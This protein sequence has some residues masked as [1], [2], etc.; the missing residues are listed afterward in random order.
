MMV[1]GW[2]G[3]RQ[4]ER[5]GVKNDLVMEGGW[6]AGGGGG[7]KQKYRAGWGQKQYTQK[8]REGAG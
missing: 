1:V 2:G 8:S 5:G 6:L 7:G 4:I 3:G